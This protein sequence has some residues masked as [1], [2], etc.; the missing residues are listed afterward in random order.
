MRNWQKEAEELLKK[1]KT[2]FIDTWDEAIQFLLDYDG[3]HGGLD[4]VAEDIID[5]MVE[6]I[7]K[8]WGH[9]RVACFLGDIIHN[10]NQ[11]FYRL[12]GYGNLTY[13]SAGWIE[14]SLDDIARGAL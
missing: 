1:F 2:S 8:E 3:E 5:E 9:Q 10:L 11:D 12:D 14:T 6:N 7:A 4:I 13:I